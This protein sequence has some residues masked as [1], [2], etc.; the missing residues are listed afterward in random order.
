MVSTLCI[1]F[2]VVPLFTKILVSLQQQYYSHYCTIFCETQ[3]E[4]LVNWTKSISRCDKV[5]LVLNLTPHHEDIW[6]SG[7][8]DPCIVKHWPASSLQKKPNAHCMGGCGESRTALH[9]L[10]KAN[11]SPVKN[12]TVILRGPACNLVTLLTEISK[13]KT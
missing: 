8:I 11:A 7:D 9:A 12:R 1:S 4:Y 2:C 3:Y 10:E 6:E 13:L 5:V